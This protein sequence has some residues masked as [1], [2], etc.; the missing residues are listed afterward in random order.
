VTFLAVALP[1]RN[2]PSVNVN[3]VRKDVMPIDYTPR[4]R[5]VWNR[6]GSQTA[7]HARPALFPGQ[8]KRCLGSDFFALMDYTVL[9]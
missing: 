6:F 9:L 3:F 5:N 8:A 4:L 7:P 2:A 1:F